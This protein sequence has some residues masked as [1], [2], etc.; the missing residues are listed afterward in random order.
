MGLS[1]EEHF[2]NYHRVLNCAVWSGLEASRV[3]LN[4]ILVALIDERSY[5]L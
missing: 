3:L 4:Q 2:Q 1:K 5:T